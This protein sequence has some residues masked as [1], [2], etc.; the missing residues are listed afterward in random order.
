M[1]NKA[2]SLTKHVESGRS[3]NFTG[4]TAP[5]HGYALIRDTSRAGSHA[6]VSDAANGTDFIG[7]YHEAYATAALVPTATNTAL[8]PVWGDVEVVASGTVELGDDLITANNGGFADASG[9]SNPNVVG[10]AL[11]AGS[12]GDTILARIWA[13]STQR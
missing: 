6:K 12:H 2:L 4:A 13:P 1:A 10:Q 7:V 8:T 11:C 3:V 5:T 9:T